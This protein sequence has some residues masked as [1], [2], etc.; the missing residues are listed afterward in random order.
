MI[1]ESPSAFDKLLGPPF[2]AGSERAWARFFD[3]S[4]VRAP[5]GM[6]G[7]APLTMRDVHAW[8]RGA[9]E[10][11]TRWDRRYLLA[12]DQAFRDEMMTRVADRAPEG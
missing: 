11:L 3:V 5:S 10:R 8:E 4:E 12:I 9:G 1:D 2:P 7:I 6:S